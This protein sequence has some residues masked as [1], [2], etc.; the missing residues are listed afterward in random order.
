[1]PRCCTI[2][3][4]FCPDKTIDGGKEYLVEYVWAKTAFT[5]AKIIEEPLFVK[6]ASQQQGSFSAS[7]YYKFPSWCTAFELTEL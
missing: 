4:G 2:A 1:V 5:T 6:A 7:F 3:F